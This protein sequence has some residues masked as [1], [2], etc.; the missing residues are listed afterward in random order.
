MRYPGTKTSIADPVVQRH[1]PVIPDAQLWKKYQTA[2]TFDQKLLVRRNG[3][4]KHSPPG[5][6]F[7]FS[8]LF[9]S[10]HRQYCREWIP[11]QPPFDIAS[12]ADFEN[13]QLAVTTQIIFGTE[14][15]SKFGAAVPQDVATPPFGQSHDMQAKATVHTADAYLR[16]R[17]RTM[18]GR[19]TPKDICIAELARKA[20][21]RQSTG[22]YHTILL[23][24]MRADDPGMNSHVLALYTPPATGDGHYLLF[25]PNGGTL[26]IPPG[27]LGKTLYAYLVGPGR[28]QWELSKPSRIEFVPVR[29]EDVETFSAPRPLTARPPLPSGI[30]SLHEQRRMLALA[31][32]GPL[33]ASEIKRLEAMPATIR[34]D[35][36]AHTDRGRDDLL[37]IAKDAVTRLRVAAKTLDGFL[38]EQERRGEAMATD[39]AE[40]AVAAHDDVH[41][42]THALSLEMVELANAARKLASDVHQRAFASSETLARQVSAA[43][44]LHGNIEFFQQVCAA[45][46]S[47]ET[48]EGAR[49]LSARRVPAA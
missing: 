16:A 49:S 29:I 5:A 4:L 46:V 15:G 31:L 26:W 42:K 36:S 45:L 7:G 20:P 40:S 23:W 18:N 13:V 47:G 12:L 25:D 27:Q 44:R 48:N 17:A 33:G 37:H 3:L 9:I 24:G 21:T 10:A 14:F 34:R 8:T 41:A 38:M 22:H 11:G 1:K 43:Q 39:E 32:D 28:Q 2:Q 6:C 19:S 35:Q 30:N